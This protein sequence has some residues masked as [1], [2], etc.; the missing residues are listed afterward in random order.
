MTSCALQLLPIYLR[1]GGMDRLQVLPRRIHTGSPQV[2][3]GILY[4]AGVI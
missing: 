4:F 1:A 3:K 2:K